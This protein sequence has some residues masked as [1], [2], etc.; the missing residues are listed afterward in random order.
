MIVAWR[1]LAYWNVANKFVTWKAQQPHEFKITAVYVL[2]AFQH[3]R[4]TK[5]NWFS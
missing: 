4:N 1:G 2:V 3:Q 5:E